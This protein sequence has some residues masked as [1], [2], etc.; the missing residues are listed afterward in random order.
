[1]KNEFNIKKKQPRARCA[2]GHSQIGCH[3]AC[4]I[5][6]FFTREECARGLLKW[7]SREGE[8]VFIGSRQ[9]YCV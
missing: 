2:I 3:F 7:S 8:L 1:M 6:T 5:V 9:G 4:Q